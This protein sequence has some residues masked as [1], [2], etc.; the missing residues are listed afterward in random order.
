MLLTRLGLLTSD[1]IILQRIIPTLLVAI[2]DQSAPVR[3]M[4]LRSLRSVL[5]IVQKFSLLESNIFPLYIFPALSRVAKDIEI[6]VRV[7]FA[8]SIGRFAETSKTFLDQAHF[9]ALQKTVSES[10][11]SSVD[12]DVGESITVEFPYNQKLEQLKEQISRWIRDLV[13]DTVVIS[14]QT[15]NV[16]DN[17]FQRNNCVNRAASTSG[18]LVKRVILMD[19]MRLCVFFGQESTMDKLLTQLLTFLNSQDWELRYAFCARISSVCAFLGPTITS[20]CILP[21]IENAIYDVEE[22]VVVCALHCLTTLTLLGLLSKF[23]IVDFTKKCKG[24]LLHPSDTVRTAVVDFLCGATNTLGHIDSIV[25]LLPQIGDMLTYDLRSVS[26]IT[27]EVLR[28]ALVSPLSRKVF[29]KGIF[30]RL[31]VMSSFN[32]T[33]GSLMDSSLCL[34]PTDDCEEDSD[35]SDTGAKNGLQ[36]KLLIMSSYL[37]LA[38]AEINTKTL[39]WR[40]G[41]MSSNITGNVF[42]GL[43]SNILTSEEVMNKSRLGSLLELNAMQMPDHS[44]QSL[45]IPHQKYGVFYFPSL[46]EDLRRN[47]LYIDN[48]GL[49]NSNKL[50]MLFGITASQADAIRALAAGAGDHWENQVS[51]INIGGNGSA[52]HVPI[53]SSRASQVNRLNF[54][55]K[56]LILFR[57]LLC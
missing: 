34:T 30:D 4:T 39:Q 27:A 50:R 28:C 12:N 43:K 38:A 22:K 16:M 36:V 21:C 13:V 31:S 19:I 41:M 54:S 45:L 53:V 11:S 49:K 42:D 56:D 25:F 20:E 9:Q 3:A 44:L 57:R 24:L 1:D 48:D 52:S 33:S 2:E 32:P 14:N 5:V 35:V 29:R 46:P 10:K 23:I 40:N 51:Q 18:S 15:G 7:A 6:I 26:A 17:S 37:D 55:G 8:E 47:V